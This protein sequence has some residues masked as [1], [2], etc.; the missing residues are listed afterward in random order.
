[1]D[2]ETQEI[3]GMSVS[4]TNE[5]LQSLEGERTILIRP[6]EVRLLHSSR[7]VGQFP[8]SEGS[9][10]AWIDFFS[11]IAPFTE[12]AKRDNDECMTSI[13]Y[14][15]SNKFRL[16]KNNLKKIFHGMDG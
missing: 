7:E 10:K 9:S 6:L 5:K 2:S 16:F 3:Q 11:I 14:L 4:M 1:M 13:W 8:W 12:K 15:E